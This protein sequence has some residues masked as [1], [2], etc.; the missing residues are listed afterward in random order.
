[1]TAE[2]DG[3]SIQVMIDRYRK[4]VTK[5]AAERFWAIRPVA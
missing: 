4:L 3:H 2:E 1:M 5:E